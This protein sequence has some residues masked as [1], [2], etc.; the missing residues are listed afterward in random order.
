MLIGRIAR[1]GALYD[2]SVSAQTSETVDA[3][4][5]PVDFEEVVD[6]SVTKLLGADSYSN[7]PGF[8]ILAE[9][10]QRAIRVNL[11]KKIKRSDN[12]KLT[13]RC[14]IY[15]VFAKAIKKLK[16]AGEITI[17]FASAERDGSEMATEV[18]CDDGDILTKGG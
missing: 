3:E 6:V 12:R 5:S 7:M 11:L 17:R 16:S 14:R 15:I 8:W 13:L 4:I 10:F 9:I 2:A 18:H 1:P